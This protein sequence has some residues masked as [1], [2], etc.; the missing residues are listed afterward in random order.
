MTRLLRQDQTFLPGDDGAVQYDDVVEACRKK[1]FDSASQW[2]LEDWISTLA[3]VGGAKKRFQYCLN[4][5]FSSHVVYLRA[6]QGHSGD[7]TD[8]ELQDNVLLPEGFAEYMYHVGHVRK[9]NSTVT[10]AIA[11]RSEGFPSVFFS[12]F[13]MFSIS[14]FFFS[15]FSRFFFISTL[16]TPSPPS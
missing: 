10:P 14:L 7:A 15:I 5:N 3:K 16:R 13:S 1:K 4:P 8:P 6:I 9:L 2:P 12:S 11:D